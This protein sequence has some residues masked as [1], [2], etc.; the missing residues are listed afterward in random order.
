MDQCRLGGHSLLREPQTKGSSNFIDSRV[1][2]GE[3][4]RGQGRR[5]QG[6][7]VLGTRSEWAESI[8]K[9]PPSSPPRR[10]W[11]RCLKTLLPQASDREPGMKEP[12]L[13]TQS[14]VRRAASLG[15]PARKAF[16]VA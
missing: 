15:R 9:F 10:P 14:G 12:L 16:I 7:K 13:G 6:G 11:Q 1:S 2:G 3:G 8:F 4:C 5:A